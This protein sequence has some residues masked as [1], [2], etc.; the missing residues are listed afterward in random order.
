[1]SRKASA[2]WSI[3]ANQAIGSLPVESAAITYKDGIVWAGCLT[4]CRSNDSGAT[5]RQ[6]PQFFDPTLDRIEDINFIDKNNGIVTTFFGAYLTT[7]GGNTWQNKLANQVDGM[8]NGTFMESPGRIA[9][10]DFGGEVWISNDAGTTWNVQRVDTNA[11]QILYRKGSLYLLASK[12]FVPSYDYVGLMYESTDDGAS[13]Q[14]LAG[15]FIADCYSLTFDSCQGVGYLTNENYFPFDTISQVLSSTD[16]GASW[17]TSVTNVPKYFTGSVEAGTNC[18]FTASNAGGVYRAIG[19]NWESIGGPNSG[20]DTRSICAINDS[21]IIAL[22]SGGSIWRTTNSAGVPINEEY[23][24]PQLSAAS[25]FNGDTLPA[26]GT[27]AKS[28][29]ILPYSG[30]ICVPPTIVSQQIV[31]PDSMYYQFTRLSDSSVASLDSDII[32]FAPDS[33]RAYSASLRITLSDG[34]V[35]LLQLGG[36]GSSGT[37]VL[38]ANRIITDTIGDLVLPLKSNINVPS[39]INLEI[40]YDSTVLVFQGGYDLD[41]TRIDSVTSESNVKILHIHAQTGLALDSVI[42]L[43]HFGFFPTQQNCAQIT[44]GASKLPGGTFCGSIVGVTT[45]ICGSGNCAQTILSDLLRNG[46]VPVFSITPNPVST[47]A[48]ITS[49]SPIASARIELL[50]TLGRMELQTTADLST[51]PFPLDLTAL[52]SGLKIVRI[53]SATGRSETRTIVVLR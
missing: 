1:M 47:V 33:A 34:Q 52:T 46:S 42:A 30:Y 12:L 19:G 11:T 36:H 31:G 50:N 29:N 8:A 53:S 3:V 5:W 4:L 25:L 45:Q 10:S 13:W 23:V 22:D 49:S 48:E 6:I 16:G 9:L 37:I 15:Q 35:L 28:V 14:S 21:L 51:D 38:S 2:Q 43:L 18:I 17:Q 20:I 44:I 32:L 24:A 41:G 39:P 7:D 40:I 26:C 27:L